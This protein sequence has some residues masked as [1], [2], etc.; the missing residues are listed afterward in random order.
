M[1]DAAIWASS[2]RVTASPSRK[3][4]CPTIAR[5]SRVGPYWPLALIAAVPLTNSVSPTGFISAGPSARYIEP[6]SM[7]TVSVIL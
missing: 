7:K 1:R 6:H 3:S 4:A 5:Q 2:T